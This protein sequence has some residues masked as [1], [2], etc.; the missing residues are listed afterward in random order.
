MPSELGQSN[1]LPPG[2][3]SIAPQFITGGL[4]APTFTTRSPGT[5]LVLR[6]TLGASSADYAIGVETDYLWL[7]VDTSSG[8]KGVKIYGG[9]SAITT[10][11]GGAS[12][13]LVMNGGTSGS[14]IYLTRSSGGQA[15]F[16]QS[17]GACYLVSDTS[18]NSMSFYTNAGA[19]IGHRMI[20]D[21]TGKVGIGTSSPG[22]ALH[23]AVDSSVVDAFYFQDTRALHTRTW[24]IGPGVGANDVFAIRDNTAG[25]NRFQ[26]DFD[27]VVKY[28]SGKIESGVTR[29]TSGSSYT[30]L[31]SDRVISFAS[32]SSGA[33]NLIASPETGRVVDV[34][35]DSGGDITLTPAAGNINGAGTLALPTGTGWALRYD[36]T[37]W[38]T[39]G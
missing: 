10:F 18:G 16:G 36:G 14:E 38:I 31:T 4:G 34:R 35:N 24:I 17:A 13:T 29:R 3:S 8:S 27:G 26:I 7:G 12:P 21:S 6:D 20:I 11:T 32:G 22:G 1:G 39:F 28:V 23:I 2:A 19:G 5:R 30:M 15:R 25:L 37:Q 33:L 9:T